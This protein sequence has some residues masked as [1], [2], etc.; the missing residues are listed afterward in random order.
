VLTLLA[1]D[2]GGTKTDLAVFTSQSGP[3]T[4]LHTAR[5]Q[6]ADYASLERVIEAFLATTN[7]TVDAACFDVPG[8]VLRGRAR[9]TNLPWMIDADALARTFDWRAVTVLNDLEA[10]GH[11]LPLLR[12]ADLHTL[13]AGEPIA[14]GTMAVIAPGT[15]LGE[16]FVTWHGGRAF[17]HPSE[18][19]HAGFAPQSECEIGLLRYL[20]ARF[21]HVSY[22]RVCS[23]IGIPSIYDYLR[24]AGEIPETAHVKE[25]LA[26]AADRTPIILE[27]AQASA[28]GCALCAATLQTF[29]SILGGEAANLALK[30]LATGGVFLGGGIPPRILPALQEGGFMRAFLRKG[31]MAELMT[32]IP[33]HVILH[34]RPALLGAASV[35]LTQAMS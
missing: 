35:G 12:P 34:S 14:D 28:A 8:P 24:D 20:L 3:D 30:M 7:V 19:G 6:S 10:V 21:D 22:E 33:V 23:G 15:G 1:G 5:F 27:H 29:V 4:P 17:A 31:R 16:A 11:A 2:I 9:A 18:G 26:T 32:R 13:N 25:R